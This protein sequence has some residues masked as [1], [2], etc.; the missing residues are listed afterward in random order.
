MTS[1]AAPG[2]TP[3]PTAAPARAPTSAR[4]RRNL[5]SDFDFSQPPRAPLP[6]RQP[7]GRLTIGPAVLPQCTAVRRLHRAARLPTCC[8]GARTPQG[9]QAPAP[10][11]PGLAVT[12][13]GRGASTNRPRSAAANSPLTSMPGRRRRLTRGYPHST[14]HEARSSPGRRHTSQTSATAGPQDDRAEPSSTSMCPGG[15][16]RQRSLSATRHRHGSRHT[17]GEARTG[18]HARSP[19]R[20]VQHREWA[21]P[22]ANYRTHIR[23]E[24]DRRRAPGPRRPRAQAGGTVTSSRLLAV[25]SNLAT[26]PALLGI[27][28]AYHT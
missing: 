20:P 26:A 5:A 22:S 2:S 3:R 24:P 23:A 1:S 16:R 11:D 6:P 13:A 21:Q 28:P 9:Q 27:E 18:G 15:T 14:G 4:T 25:I 8:Q 12:G 17:G 7:A 19:G 10:G